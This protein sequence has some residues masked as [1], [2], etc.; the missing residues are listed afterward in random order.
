M[1]IIHGL[2]GFLVLSS[3]SCGHP[4]VSDR[5]AAT[6]VVPAED[7]NSDEE[8]AI[9]NGHGVRDSSVTVIEVSRPTCKNGIIGEVKSFCSAA[10]VD[11]VTLL[12][13]AHCLARLCADRPVQLNKIK[14][15]RRFSLKQSEV[16][17]EGENLN[18]MSATNVF[19]FPGFNGKTDAVDKQIRSSV[20]LALVKFGSKIEGI[21][22]SEF[23]IANGTY[24]P[25]NLFN[26]FGYGVSPG[27]SVFYLR[28]GEVYFSNVFPTLVIGSESPSGFRSIMVKPRVFLNHKNDLTCSGDSGGPMK[29]NG[30]VVGILSASYSS[31]SSDD[32]L[33]RC[34]QVSSNTFTEVTEGVVANAVKELGTAS[35]AQAEI[36]T[37]TTVELTD[38]FDS[39]ILNAK[40]LMPLQLS[41]WNN[42]F[43][44]YAGYTGARVTRALALAA[45][46]STTSQWST[47]AVAVTGKYKIQASY[48]PDAA[49]TKCARYEFFDNAR[50]AVK[51]LGTLNHSVGTPPTGSNVV[52][53]PIV[54]LTRISLT[55]GKV[56]SVKLTGRCDAIVGKYM[57][58]DAIKVDAVP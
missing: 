32:A 26:I 39:L 18:T 1:K 51:T 15:P 11:K 55:V 17:V 3:F 36:G 53:A 40:L 34:G 12:T 46:S 47:L 9:R 37:S 22:K 27:N 49:N 41:P 4:T 2:L 13:A 5:G 16:D 35:S 38:D 44:E 50:P 31:S 30:K 24:R 19:L 58:A 42:T 33:V 21:T 29:R 43:S 7:E 28:R 56:Y 45:P 25:S 54:N 10:V 23:A 8:L 57:H 14:T 48:R 6:P 20:D 52:M